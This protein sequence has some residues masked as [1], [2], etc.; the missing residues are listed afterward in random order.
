VEGLLRF[1]PEKNTYEDLL[2]TISPDI[3]AD[4]TEQRKI[5]GRKIH[6]Y[7]QINGRKNKTAKG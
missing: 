1:D 5:I 6:F 3:P 2:V 4:E 7:E